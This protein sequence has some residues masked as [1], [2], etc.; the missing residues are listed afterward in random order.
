MRPW[1]LIGLGLFVAV[2]AIGVVI[3]TLPARR[4]AAEQEACKN[5]LRNLALF[6][7]THANPPKGTPQ[8]KVAQE[9]PAG[10][11]LLPGVEPEERLSWVADALPNFDQ[12]L[13]NTMEINSAIARK[14]PWSAAKN[15][16][17]ARNKVNALL[18]PGNPTAIDPE[19]PAPTQYVGIGG[20]APD[21]PK[22]NFVPPSPAP[23]RAGC[24]RYDDPTPFF[25]ITDGLSQSLLFGERSD[26][27]G[28]WLRGG[29]STIRGL[30]DSPSAKPLIGPGGQFGGNHPE[31]SNWAFADGGVRSFTPRV[32]RK[33]LLGL[34]TIAGRETDAIPG[35]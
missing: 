5:N 4:A 19:Q 29:P 9:I 17:A 31:T 34:A 18:C 22:L 33:V 13:Q 16:D 12:K 23:P 14:E 24:F 28:P 35:E 15:Q 8:S 2:F 11:I 21:G 1:I 27:L 7:A 25:A 20:L 30:D 32:D 26:D 6:A 10:T 3:T